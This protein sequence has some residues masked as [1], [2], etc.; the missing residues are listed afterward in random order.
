MEACLSL[1]GFGRLVKV[2]GA[3]ASKQIFLDIVC[4]QK[5]HKTNARTLRVAQLRRFKVAKSLGYEG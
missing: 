1:D 3:L 2:A 4:N 5:M